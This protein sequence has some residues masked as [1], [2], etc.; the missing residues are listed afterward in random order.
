MK[1]SLALLV[2]D[3]GDQGL[4]HIVQG[5]YQSPILVQWQKAERGARQVDVTLTA[6][7]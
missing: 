1:R 3:R 2:S 5:P 4:G 7:S 6:L